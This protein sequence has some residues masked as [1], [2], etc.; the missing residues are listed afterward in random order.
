MF[1]ASTIF[2]L[3]FLYAAT[4]L[5][6]AA[7]SEI[8]KPSEF[9]K[10]LLTKDLFDNVPPEVRS[11]HAVGTVNVVVW[12]DAKGNVEKLYMSG[13]RDITF[14]RE[15]VETEVARW[16]FKP[17]ERKGELVP[18]RGAVSIPFCYGSFPKKRWC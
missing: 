17:L 9:K 10:R 1:R 5:P 18:Y 2:I 13:F 7:Q 3:F 11:F 4:C 6:Q 8:L 16:K 14:L 12:V 15:Y